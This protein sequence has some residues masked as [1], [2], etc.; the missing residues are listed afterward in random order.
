MVPVYVPAASPVVFTDTTSVLG[1]VPEV[2]VTL[3]QLPPDVVDALADHV[4]VPPPAF[5]N[6]TFCAAG[7]AP[8]AVPLKVSVAGVKAIAGPGG[9]TLSVTATVCGVLVAPGA[10]TVIVPLY[11]PAAKPEM[12][13]AA[14]TVL[15][16]VPEVGETLS[17]LPPEVVEAAAVQV[18]VPPPVLEISTFWFAGLDPP[19]V[20]VKVSEAGVN[21]MVGGG[22]ATFNVTAMVCGEFVAPAAVMVMVPL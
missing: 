5:V 19:A 21:A 13:T 18:I 16:A 15:G 10:V 1:A 9:F 14:A 3:S 4:S 6:E 22:A 17:Q 20:A 11:V 8:P 12:F 2:G 7:L